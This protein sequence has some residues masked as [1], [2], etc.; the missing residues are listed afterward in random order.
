MD[1]NTIPVL[2]LRDVNTYYT[3]IS[4]PIITTTSKTTI[5]P[6][7]E[8]VK[9]YYQT[10]AKADESTGNVAWIHFI[11]AMILILFLI[12]VGLIYATRSSLYNPDPL[13]YGTFVTVQE[14]PCVPEDSG[15]NWR[16]RNGTKRI[17][18]RCIPNPR[19][20]FGCLVLNGVSKSNISRGE[21][22]TYVT[23]INSLPCRTAKAYSDWRIISETSCGVV[24]EDSDIILGQKQVTRL[25]DQIGDNPLE[26]NY[27]ID[28]EGTVY[29]I[30][31]TWTTTEDCFIPIDNTQ[32]PLGEWQIVEPPSNKS[33]DYLGSRVPSSC[34]FLPELNYQQDCVPYDN[35]WEE[36]PGGFFD[37]LKEGMVYTP[38]TC[39]AEECDGPNKGIL[40]TYNPPSTDKCQE[41]ECTECKQDPYQTI[42]HSIP[43]N[44]NPVLC[45]TD[46]PECLQFCR[47]SPDNCNNL[48]ERF[49]LEDG[50]PF[51]CLVGCPVVFYKGNR[52]LRL[53]GQL[54]LF[55]EPIEGTFP[56]EYPGE[57]VYFL[58]GPREL[59]DD[60][61]LS[62]SFLG[63]ANNQSLGWLKRLDAGGSLPIIDWEP[64]FDNINSYD[65]TSEDAEQFELKYDPLTMTY[66]LPLAATDNVPL[67]MMKLVTVSQDEDEEEL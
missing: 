12:L 62:A 58:L 56:P 53:I 16:S 57:A 54:Y 50:S 34:D 19:T 5:G 38:M 41:L 31:D 15:S 35:T 17:V 47:V 42:D 24:Q 13:D 3:P 9:Q 29:N 40:L 33:P 7:Q 22:V 36:G 37:V 30:G 20:N 25:C 48:P 49:R 61:T 27:C 28:D 63:F 44:Q 6:K 46:A 65:T 60:N 1:T 11:V 21:Y 64:A 59:I 55:S 2:P 4:Q 52:M 67:N 66:S 45:P 26:P 23:Q 43:S 10:P 51:N 18:Q 8:V 39:V 32:C 14:G